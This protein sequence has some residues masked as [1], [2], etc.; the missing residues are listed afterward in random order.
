MNQII[1]LVLLNLLVV[2]ISKNNGFRPV[3][4]TNL[5]KAITHKLN[6]IKSA[7]NRLFK[8]KT[9]FKEKKEKKPIIVEQPSEEW[10]SGEVAWDFDEDIMEKEEK[11]LFNP[12][13]HGY[14]L[15]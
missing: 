6:R 9:Y 14:I 10:E 12:F 4:N 8:M 7:R 1:S 11:M 3:I 2:V 5:K 15:F 13:I